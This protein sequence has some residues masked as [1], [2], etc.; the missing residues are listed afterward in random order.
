MPRMTSAPRPPVARPVAP[1]KSTPRHYT[2]SPAPRPGAGERGRRSVARPG[3]RRV[4][5]TALQHV[6]AVHARGRDANQQLAYARLRHLALRGA[7]H[8]GRPGLSDLD[9]DHVLW[10]HRAPNGPVTRRC[11]STPLALAPLS[12]PAAAAFPVRTPR[13]DH[14][15]PGASR[16]AA[17]APR[18]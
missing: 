12:R 2:P 10:N 7:Q 11:A 15:A 4:Q 18:A 1:T 9:R 8:L 3:G 16:P 5:A 6:G 13:D 17:R 14:S